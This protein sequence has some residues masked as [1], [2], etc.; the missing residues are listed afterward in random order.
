MAGQD[1]DDLRG[2]DLSRL[3]L[4]HIELDIE[5]PPN[6]AWRWAFGLLLIALAVVIAASGS[7]ISLSNGA[8]SFVLSLAAVIVGISLG[9]WLWNIALAR[10]AMAD[11]ADIAP[12]PKGPASLLTRWV[13][14]LL[15][16]GGAVGVVVLS[17][18]GTLEQWF[19]PGALFG[20]AAFAI[21]SGIILGRWLMM[22][23]EAAKAEELI[24]FDDD[25]APIEL[26][27]WFKWVT[28]TVIVCVGVGLLLYSVVGGEAVAGGAGMGG[29]GFAC[30][31]AAA[32]WVARRFDEIEDSKKKP[33]RAMPE[34][35]GG[36]PA[37]VT[38]L[39]EA[40]E[41]NVRHLPVGRSSWEG[42]RDD[43]HDLR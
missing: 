17:R 22:Q 13:T 32:I 4:D 11:P 40:S 8:A 39:P 10:A 12:E 19:G 42:P 5:R 9:R 41:R 14:F 18:N 1:Y 15:G 16:A 30:G 27:P 25:G 24:D 38:L 20:A 36:R 29:L 37:P 26:P 28:L 3:D 43:D 35:R 6:P 31:I 33:V 34:R 21:V 7:R 23:A 2:F